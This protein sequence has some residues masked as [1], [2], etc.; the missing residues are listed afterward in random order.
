MNDAGRCCV[1]RTGRPTRRGMPRRNWPS[2]WIPPVEAP[3][4]RTRGVL[5]EPGL[6]LSGGGAAIPGIRRRADAE[7]SAR[8]LARRVSGYPSS[9][10]P[11]SGL[12]NVS[13]AP[14]AKAAKVC[15][16]PSTV[17]EETTMIRAPCAAAMI[18]GRP[19]SPP[20]P[21]MSRSS[22]ITSTR[23]SPS[24]RIACS[25]VPAT[26]TTAISSSPATMREWTVRAV[27]ES[28][29]TMTFS[30]TVRVFG[31]DPA[32]PGGSPRGLALPRLIERPS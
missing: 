21:G 22:R 1:T 10:L 24:K 19:S 6:A 29:T 20:I 17:S 16:A 27:T 25:A 31:A 5:P 13:A 18:R 7:P 8:T 12:G 9:K 32:E 11:A 30:G 23:T 15:S 28:S 2:A 4:A 14:R 26:A 3:M